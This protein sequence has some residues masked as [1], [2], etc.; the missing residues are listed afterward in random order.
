M[1]H[2]IISKAIII[3][4][5]LVASIHIV[6]NVHIDRIEFLATCCDGLWRGVFELWEIMPAEGLDEFESFFFIY[7]YIYFIYMIMI[8][9][10]NRLLI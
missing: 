1:L 7:F 2:C 10:M 3:G 6:P 4:V 5:V 9:G 8:N